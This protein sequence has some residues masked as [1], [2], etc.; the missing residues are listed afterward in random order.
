MG[1]TVLGNDLILYFNPAFV[2]GI[3][4]DELGGVLLHE[5]HHVV[6]GHVQAD[7]ADFPD[8]WARTVAEE[9]TVNEFVREPL[10]S[11]VITL[12]LFPK[13]PPMESTR[14]RYDRLRRITRRRPIN[15]PGRGAAPAQPDCRTPSSALGATLDDHSVWTSARDDPERSAAAVRDVLQHAAMEVGAAQV[16]AEIREACEGQGI[17]LTAGETDRATGGTEQGHLDWRR[18][19]RQHIGLSLEMRPAFDR[20]PRRF[21]ELIG[22]V[23]AH[24][25][26]PSRPRIM[27]IIDTSGSIS[28][29]LLE[30]I[31]A[32]LARLARTHTVKVVECDCAIRRVYDYRPVTARRGGGGTDFRPPLEPTF[33]RRH[34]PDLITYFTDGYGHAPVTA[35]RI[36]VI[37]CL[38]PGG[39][40]PAPWGRVIRMDNQPAAH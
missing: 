28:G 3:S 21:P 13:L 19:L 39:E 20:P 35:P 2:L 31:D 34:Q 22:I 6:L 36:P 37:W 4:A 16:P 27:A 11:G 10:P 40:R 1:V 17:G 24:R 29:G 8:D 23:P 30:A 14:Q 32:E 9:V 15:S 38:T 12:D 18:L 26:R 33:L 5:V 25:C 7:P